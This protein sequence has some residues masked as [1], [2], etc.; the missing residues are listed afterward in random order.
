MVRFHFLSPPD[1]LARCP[2][3]LHF[4]VSWVTAGSGVEPTTRTK[5]LVAQ[6]V[7]RRYEFEGCCVTP[8]THRPE[9]AEADGSNPSESTGALRHKT[10]RTGRTTHMCEEHATK[11]SLYES[12]VAPGGDRTIFRRVRPIFRSSCVRERCMESGTYAP[13]AHYPLQ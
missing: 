4:N 13:C 11:T 5:G 3:I 7:A 2:N 6:L 9:R 1:L 10:S 12:V 8:S